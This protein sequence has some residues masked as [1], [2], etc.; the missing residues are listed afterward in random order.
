MHFLHVL[1]PHLKWRGCPSL[2][3]LNTH[4]QY[5]GVIRYASPVVLMERCN[6]LATQLDVV[7]YE[8]DTFCGC[9]DVWALSVSF[10]CMEVGNAFYVGDH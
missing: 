3:V 2:T 10:V 5:I 1:Q 8:F 6:Q 9:V 7:G 4:V